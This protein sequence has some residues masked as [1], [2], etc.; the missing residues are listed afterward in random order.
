LFFE[1]GDIIALRKATLHGSQLA[2][3]S[4]WINFV[5]RVRNVSSTTLTVIL[6]VHAILAFSSL[7]TW[8]PAFLLGWLNWFYGAYMP[9]MS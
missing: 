2:K 5:M 8:L 3:K 7:A 6:A 9:P 1:A 4:Q